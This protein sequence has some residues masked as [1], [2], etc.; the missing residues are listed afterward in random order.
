MNAPLTLMVDP[1]SVVGLATYL[2]SSG[3]TLSPGQAAAS[4]INEWLASRAPANGKAAQPG[5]RGYRWKCLFLPELTQ[6]RMHYDGR[7]FHAQVI[8]DDIIFDGQRVSP[9]QMTLLIAGD[10]R[11]AWRDLLLRYPGESTW[12]HGTARR[13]ALARQPA[14]PPALTAAETI[15]AA[16]AAMAQA[17]TT[18]LE[19]VGRV[20]AESEH[21]FERRTERRRRTS[22]VM[23]DD[24]RND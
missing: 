8:G 5:P 1:T 13:N 10:G 3:S 7:T 23:E 15:G 20:N 6:I 21:I 17:L 14:P 9:R 12:L 4:A 18:A 2:A 11:N 22:D 24:C 16:A 19:L